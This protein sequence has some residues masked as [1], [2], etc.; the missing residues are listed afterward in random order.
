MRLRGALVGYFPSSTTDAG[1]AIFLTLKA[2]LADGVL[3]E[4]SLFESHFDRFRPRCATAGANKAGREVVYGTIWRRTCWIRPFN[5]WPAGQ[6]DGG[7]SATASGRAVYRLFPRDFILPQRRVILHGTM[8][9]AA[10]SAR[11]IVHG[12]RGSYVNMASI[13][14]NG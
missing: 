8:L 7:F 11:Y 1:T 14:K 2:L 4:V 10:E 6:H 9:T 13:G 12:S 3:G 5:F